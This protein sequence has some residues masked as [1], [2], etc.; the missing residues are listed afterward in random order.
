MRKL[1]ISDWLFLTCVGVCTVVHV[2]GLFA[3]H[4]AS[5]VM[6]FIYAYIAIKG[7]WK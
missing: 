1:T 7:M 5:Y 3:G 2:P 6:M 4:A